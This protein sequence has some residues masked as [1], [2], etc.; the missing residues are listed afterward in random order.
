MV[1]DALR[2]ASR[3]S[4]VWLETTLTQTKRGL[5][6]C[7]ESC[8]SGLFGRRLALLTTNVVY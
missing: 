1:L 2:D 6:L 4:G 7:L 8:D 3:L 5:G